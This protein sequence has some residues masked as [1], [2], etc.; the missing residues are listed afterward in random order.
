MVTDIDQIKSIIKP[1]LF[2]LFTQALGIDAATSGEAGRRLRQ[3]YNSF[4]RYYLLL[5]S[6]E[7]L[8]EIAVLSGTKSM[9]IPGVGDSNIRSALTLLKTKSPQDYKN[10]IELFGGKVDDD[11]KHDPRD[12]RKAFNETARGAVFEVKDFNT[13]TAWSINSLEKFF[14]TGDPT[15]IGLKRGFG[16][17]PELNNKY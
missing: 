16:Y 3:Q 17:G 12:L 11:R 9:E 1:N 6:S 10:I 5:I 2:N 14:K 15:V 7:A 8:E 4:I 13:D